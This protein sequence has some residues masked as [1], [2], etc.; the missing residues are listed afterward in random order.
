MT[1][2]ITKQKPSHCIS[3]NTL[4]L[5]HKHH[6]THSHIHTPRHTH[7]H[8]NTFTHG[9]ESLSLVAYEFSRFL[10]FCHFQVNFFPLVSWF[11]GFCNHLQLHFFCMVS[12]FL[13]FWVF[14]LRIS[15]FEWV[16]SVS[17][18]LPFS[19]ATLFPFYFSVSWFLPSSSAILFLFGFSVSRF[20]TI[21]L[22]DY[23]H[24]VG[25]LA[26]SCFAIIFSYCTLFCSVSYF[27]GFWGFL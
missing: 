12:R 23:F 15:F 22:T 24:F 21:S 25:F 10:D 3:L 14:L 7:S 17:R 4:L 16:F 19:S 1:I 5:S 26:F 13:G 9:D 6:H 2:V 8:A 18:F 11:R 20:L 27:L